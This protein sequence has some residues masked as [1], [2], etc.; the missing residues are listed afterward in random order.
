MEQPIAPL[1]L[2][3]LY[4][5]RSNCQTAAMMTIQ[6]VLARPGPFEHEQAG[7]DG[8]TKRTEAVCLRWENGVGEE[9]RE[10]AEEERK[11]ER[12]EVEVP[13]LLTTY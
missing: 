7:A 5:R 11:K 4:W 6:E 13:R 12:G 2:G 3:L 8:Q 1:A 10:K 9:M